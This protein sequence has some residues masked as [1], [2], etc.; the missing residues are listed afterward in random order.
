[1]PSFC[2]FHHFTLSIIDI[3]KSIYQVRHGLLFLP[4]F[5]KAYQRSQFLF[6]P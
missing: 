2:P 5:T 3:I 1:M 6:F 4:V